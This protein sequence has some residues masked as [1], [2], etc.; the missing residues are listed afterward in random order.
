MADSS[1][2]KRKKDKNPKIK[3]LPENASSARTKVEPLA[4]K[5]QT[6]VWQISKIDNES[7]WGWK[8]VGRERWERTIL[9]HLVNRES[10]TWAAIET[11]PKRRGEGSKN[12]EVQVSRIIPEAQKRLVDLKREDYDVLFSLRVTGKIRIWGNREGRVFQIFW[13]DLDHEICPC[14]K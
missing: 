8:H 5:L 13:F 12:H 7:K 1:P 9:P 4:Y 14:I 11:E 6:P 3:S 10:M 2:K